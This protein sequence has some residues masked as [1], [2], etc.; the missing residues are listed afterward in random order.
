MSFR[1]AAGAVTANIG[2][3]IVSLL[4]AALLWLHVTAQQMEN[5]Y[6]RVPLVLSRI[7]DSLTVTHD[8]PREVEVTVHGSKIDLMK[9]RL[10]G[11]LTAA[12]DLSKAVRGRNTIPLNAVAL[13]LPEQFD[14]REVTVNEPKSLVL[15]FDKV[16]TRPV[17]VRIVW[18][19]DEPRDVVIEGD[20]VIIPARVQVTGAASIVGAIES[21]PTREVD[22]RGRRGRFSQDVE[23]V[24]GGRDITVV[25][26][27]VLIE[28]SIQKRSVR[29]IANI[30]PT[31]LQDRGDLVIEYSPKFVSLTIE[32]PE[33][34]IRGITADDVSVILNVATRKTGTHR[35]EP[36][37]IVPRGIEKYFLDIDAFDIRIT[38][39]AARGGGSRP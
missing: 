11:R 34:V 29:T 32:G 12:V 16:V 39:V 20:P 22:I 2:A 31:L 9:L 7:P 28:L 36:E 35:I 23:V 13:N 5:Q 26:D 38:P 37:V 24:R 3:K 25:P 21:L 14:P 27:K 19:G 17:P 8:Y 10:V 15:N 30:P 6:F 33:D 4:F 1:K 18:K